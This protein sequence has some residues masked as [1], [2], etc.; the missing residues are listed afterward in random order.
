MLTLQVVLSFGAQLITGTGYKLCYDK[1]TEAMRVSTLK[2]NLYSLQI[3]VQMC[4]PAC[5]C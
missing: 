1:H 2:H 4:K 5:R 3:R